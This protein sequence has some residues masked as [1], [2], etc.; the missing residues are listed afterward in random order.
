MTSMGLQFGNIGLQFGNDSQYG[1][2]SLGAA[3][4][5]ASHYST[6]A[7]VERQS[8][9]QQAEQQQQR[10]GTPHAAGTGTSAPTAA[11]SALEA[12]A[13]GLAGY[14]Q[15]LNAGYSSAYTVQ[16]S[17]APA[18][19]KPAPAPA[20][21]IRLQVNAP[22][23]HAP[24]LPF[25]ALNS[26]LAGGLAPPGNSG[27]CKV[28]SSSLLCVVL[29]VPRFWDVSNTAVSAVSCAALMQD[30]AISSQPFYAAPAYSQAPTPS[31]SQAA[32]MGYNA[33]GG[34][35]AASTAPQQPAQA[36]YSYQA[37]AA[38]QPGYAATAQQQSAAPAYQQQY[39]QY[40]QAQQ[41]QPAASQ[42]S[43]QQQY[44]AQSVSSSVGGS[45]APQPA[46][47][48][49]PSCPPAAEPFCKR[50]RPCAAGHISLVT[51]VRWPCVIWGL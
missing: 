36:A 23:L 21:P 34:Y 31:A 3:A 13:A 44:D 49:V 11:P 15:G 8:S 40:Q 48:A 16:Q 6:A 37:P 45:T 51:A 46:K 12:F 30:A 17:Q 50:L 4:G 18:A 28:P 42:P 22:C 35:Q 2:S 27:A 43:Y 24:A 39:N 47:P 32:A 25:H 14:P 9:L 5:D 20:A 38:S 10:Q 33:L 41:Q 1:G 7:A 19:S 26:L 29:V